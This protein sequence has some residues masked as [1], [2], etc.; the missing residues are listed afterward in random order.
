MP[1]TNAYDDLSNKTRGLNLG[2]S[3]YLYPYSEYPSREGS[4]ESVYMPRLA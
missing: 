2:M 3:L 1:I 4:G